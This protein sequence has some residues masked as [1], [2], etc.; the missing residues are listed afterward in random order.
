MLVYSASSLETNQQR[1]LWKT[2]CSLI[3][4]TCRILNPIYVITWMLLPCFFFPSKPWNN[5]MSWKPSNLL[6]FFSYGWLHN[7]I[8][9]QSK[10]LFNQVDLYSK[11]FFTFAKLFS[12]LLTLLLPF[13][14]TCRHTEHGS[15]DFFWYITESLLEQFSCFSW[16][17]GP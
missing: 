3:H 14:H 13:H 16:R 1:R 9:L 8:L 10:Q 2:I 7:A 15:S 4:S 5:C 11:S 6:V 17:Q 12:L